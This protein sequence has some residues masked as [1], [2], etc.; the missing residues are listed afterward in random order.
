[1]DDDTSAPTNDSG[2]ARKRT[3]PTIE[4][5]AQDVSETA[6]ASDA[7]AAES[8]PPESETSESQ[9]PDKT[10]S[11][12]T[13][14]PDA[15]APHVADDTPPPPPPPRRGAAGLL[16]LSAVTG[17]V[18][19]VAVLG[20]AMFAGWPARN[21]VAPLQNIASKSDVDALGAR[22]AG[23]EAAAAKPAPAP[24]VV[25]DPA[26]VARLDALDKSVAALREQVAAARSQGDKAVAALGDIKAA[27]PPSAA[28][29]V[30][31]A[32]IDER[33]GQLER[34][35]SALSAAAA[36]PAPPPPPPPED[37]RLRRAVAAML[38][39]S[40]VRQG[41]PF[42]A[43]LAAARANAGDATALAPLDAFAATGIPSA[44]ALS[45]ELM[46]LL[47]RLAPK[48]TPAAP[49]SGLVER[50]QHS[51]ARLVRVERTDAPSSDAGDGAVVARIAAAA[52]RDDIAGARREMDQLAPAQRAVVQ[53]WIAKADARAAALSA[54]RQFAADTMTALAGSV[55]AKSAR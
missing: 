22:L 20:A 38:L 54:A 25:T 32:A 28:P 50:L 31:T 17:A 5:T 46:A 9:T 48:E 8:S 2:A 23:V 24:R 29:A 35:T 49:S 10:P 45:R 43:A 52:R 27:A 3:P 30:D 4:L 18:V 34:A 51:A 16:L 15:A 7:P 55:P 53:P 1:M 41:E 39:E 42:A 40:A 14:A 37:P 47:P 11:E 21:A 26:V 13:P 19:S 12:Q 36:K 33:L 6:R 44:A